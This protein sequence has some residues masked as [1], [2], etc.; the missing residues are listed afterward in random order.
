MASVTFVARIAH[1][2]YKCVMLDHHVLC[3]WQYLLFFYHLDH[4]EAPIDDMYRPL[5]DLC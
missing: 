3:A 5:C 2:V 1:H 4:Y